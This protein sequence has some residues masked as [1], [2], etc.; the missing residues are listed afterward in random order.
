MYLYGQTIPVH[1]C[2]LFNQICKSIKQMTCIY[3]TGMGDPRFRRWEYWGFRSYLCIHYTGDHSV[4]KPFRHRSTKHCW[5]P[6][7]RSAPKR[8]SY[9]PKCYHI[10]FYYI[11]QLKVALVESHDFQN[12]V[13]LKADSCSPVQ[14]GSKSEGTNLR[15]RFML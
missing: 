8:V 5:T 11:I 14:I 12:P 7:I 4:F 13:A 6:Y 9:Q 3:Y 1:A 15:V 2:L 10:E